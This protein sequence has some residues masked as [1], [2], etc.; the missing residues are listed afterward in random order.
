L[1][2]LKQSDTAG[3]ANKNFSTMIIEGKEYPV[4]KIIQSIWGEE[5]LCIVTVSKKLKEGQ[6]RG[7][8]QTLKKKYILLESFKNQL[9]NPKKRKIFSKEEIEE[10]LK[11]IIRGQFIEEILEYEFITLEGGFISFI[12][13]INNQAFN[14]LQTDILGRQIIVTNRYEWTTEEIILAYRGQGKVEYAFRC[15][16]NPFHFAVRPQYHWTDQKIEVHILICI[17][18]YLLAVSIYI[19]AKKL[20]YNRNINNFLTELSKIRLACSVQKKGR[21]IK[22]QLE[23]IPAHLRNISKKLGITNDNIRPKI[24]ISDYT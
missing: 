13:F 9:E 17:I 15:L 21:N 19:K 22:Y 8:R 18:G 6:I 2:L 16:K 4:Y 24:N 1:T 3:N 10:R 11:K 20:D 23:K 12:Y 7:I 5:R 14:K